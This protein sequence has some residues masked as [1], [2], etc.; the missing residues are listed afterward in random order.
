MESKL[1]NDNQDKV[2]DKVKDKVAKFIKLVR[3]DN[4]GTEEYD[5]SR[6][7]AWVNKL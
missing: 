3:N 6:A 7:N 2:N 5:R 4:S 1:K